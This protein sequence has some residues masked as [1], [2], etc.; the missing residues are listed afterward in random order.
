M[1]TANEMSHFMYTA[2][3][4]RKN[5]FSSYRVVQGLYDFKKGV[6]CISGGFHP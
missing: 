4:D 1:T 2:R 6:G 5:Q 3:T